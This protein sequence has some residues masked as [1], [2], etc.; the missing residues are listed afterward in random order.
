LTRA[1]KRAHH[2]AILLD[3]DRGEQAAV[4]NSD[5][6]AHRETRPLARADRRMSST[7]STKSRQM[8]LKFTPEFYER[9]AALARNAKVP[10]VEI[11]ERAIE[12]YALREKGDA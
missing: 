12:A 8:N 3:V 11:V 10:M 2:N 9:V 5:R 1:T 7:P 6:Q 4:R